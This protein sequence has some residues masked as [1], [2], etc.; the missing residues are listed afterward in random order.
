MDG[1]QVGDVV[2]S[3]AVVVD[4]KS[5]T[6]SNV[7]A[8]SDYTLTVDGTQIGDVVNSRAIVRDQKLFTV[9]NVTEGSNYTLTVDG[10]QIGNV[11]NSP[12]IVIDKKIFTVSNVTADSNYTLTVDGSQVGNTVN[13]RAIILDKKLFTVNNVTS[14]T[15]YTLTINNVTIGNSVSTGSNTSQKQLAVLLET[16]YLKHSSVNISDDVNWTNTKFLLKSD[17]TSGSTTFVD[18]SDDN[19]VISSGGDVEHNSTIKKFGATAINLMVM[20]IIWDDTALDWHTNVT[21]DFTIECWAYQVSSAGAWN[22]AIR[23]NN[24]SQAHPQGNT[25]LIGAGD[26]LS[27]N[28]SDVYYTSNRLGEW[29]HYALVQDN[30]SIRFYVNGAMKYSQSGITIDIL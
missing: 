12:A 25:I 11:V 18:S 1:T 2:N 26:N 15:S 10:T 4:Q 22:C 17:T 20:E 14:N 8:D 9:S 23:I 27:F 24:L 29:V 16:E 3:R 19:N 13:S 30:S 28:N 5:L 7:T 21:Q 6:V